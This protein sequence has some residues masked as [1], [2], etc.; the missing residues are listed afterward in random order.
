VTPDGR[1]LLFRSDEPGLDALSG[2]PNGGVAQYYRYRAPERTLDCISCPPEDTG[3]MQPVPSSLSTAQ[4]TTSFGNVMTADGSVVYFKTTTPLMPQ[5][6]NDSSDI[7]EWREGRVTL[8]T[9]GTSASPSPT[10]DSHQIVGVTADGSAFYFASYAALVPDAQKGLTN[11]YSWREGAFSRSES[12]TPMCT[13]DTCQG[14][15]SGRPS[16]G[17]P[18]SMSGERDGNLDV[19][20]PPEMRVDRVGPRARRALARGRA[21]PLRVAV[22][23]PG[24]VRVRMSARVRGLRAVVGTGRRVARA[25]TT[26]RIPLRLNR[27]GRAELRRRGRL[28]IRIVVTYSALAGSRAQTVILRAAPTTKER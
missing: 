14:L 27:A 18:S 9:D 5:D 6:V 10:G 23:A 7:Y 3:R 26:L 21:A 15:P 11:L 2:R 28:T 22:T 12:A 24:T 20:A 4:T 1:T 25:A 13:G 17:A 8:I 19:P 16:S